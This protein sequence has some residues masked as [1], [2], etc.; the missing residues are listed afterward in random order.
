MAAKRKSS[1]PR[2]AKPKV[3][4]GLNTARAEMVLSK[5]FQAATYGQRGSDAVKPLFTP[6]KVQTRRTPRQRTPR[7]IRLLQQRA[8]TSEALG[9]SGGKPLSR[10]QRLELGPAITQEL[11][12]AICKDRKARREVLF[13]SGGGKP[14]KSASKRRN[15]SVFSDIRC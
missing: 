11:R 9:K 15:R 4:R 3:S 1:R 2:P 8:I 12:E 7:Q 5:A 6:S 13:A 10:R 14:R